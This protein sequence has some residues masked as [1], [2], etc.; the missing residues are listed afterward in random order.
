MRACVRACVCACERACVSL[1]VLYLLRLLFYSVFYFSFIGWVLW[2]LAIRLANKRCWVEV[3]CRVTPGSVCTA[4]GKKTREAVSYWRAPWPVVDT[5]ST[6]RATCKP[7]SFGG[8]P[9]WKQRHAHP[10]T[11]SLP[12]HFYSW[13]VQ[14]G[15]GHVLCIVRPPQWPPVPLSLRA[16]R[17]HWGCVQRCAPRGPVGRCGP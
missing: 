1:T 5:V 7:P 15:G 17:L 14:H 13:H 2:L 16:P 11:P 12:P 9:S 6:L 10:V 8:N 3:P 4:Q